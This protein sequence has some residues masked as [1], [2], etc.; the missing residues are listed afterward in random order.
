MELVYIVRKKW[1]IL[2]V[3]EGMLGVFL[4]VFQN[5]N[6]FIPQPLW[7]PEYFSAEP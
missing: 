1:C 6:V 7:K 4:T 2:P 5:W 3:F